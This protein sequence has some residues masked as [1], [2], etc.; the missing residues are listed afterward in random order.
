[1]GC[2]LILKCSVH[3]VYILCLSPQFLIQESGVA[4]IDLSLRKAAY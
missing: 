1:M 3:D 4:Y 2:V